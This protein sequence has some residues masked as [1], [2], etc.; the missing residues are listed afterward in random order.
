LAG[1][2]KVSSG[3]FFGKNTIGGFGRLGAAAEGVEAGSTGD[4]VDAESGIGNSSD[5]SPTWTDSFSDGLVAGAVSW[6]AGC[7]PRSLSSNCLSK[8]CPEA[9]EPTNSPQ[10]ANPIHRV[11]DF[12]ITSQSL[13]GGCGA[14]L[15]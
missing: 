8:S 15:S 1:G 2:L 11:N 13:G 6:T 4:A 7:L 14:I 3:F 9:D 12:M 10:T 5:C